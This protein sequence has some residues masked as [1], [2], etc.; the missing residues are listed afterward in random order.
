M[1][2]NEIGSAIG[3]QGWVTPLLTTLAGAFA[4]LI[5][6]A[7]NNWATD[8]R[9]QRQ[10][11]N[12]AAER[13]KER[14]A[15]LRRE[16][17][18]SL[19]GGLSV[20]SKAM[21]SLVSTDFDV[22]ILT[23]SLQTFGAEAA[24]AMM[25]GSD[26]T[27]VIVAWMSNRFNEV[28]S[29]AIR[30]RQPLTALYAQMNTQDE[31]IAEGRGEIARLIKAMKDTSESN[32][33]NAN[34]PNL[35]H[36]LENEMKAQQE[37]Q[38]ERLTLGL[39]FGRLQIAVGTK[40]AKSAAEFAAKHTDLI[41]AMRDDLDLPKMSLNVAKKIEG[42]SETIINNFEKAAAASREDLE[43]IAKTSMVVSA[44]DQPAKEMKG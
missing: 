5:G 7:L 36:A 23:S 26:R 42:N 38:R 14:T 2:L 16:V 6:V 19:V 21:G 4:A 33:P 28:A 41:S 17:Y 25:V 31:F 30:E 18:F 10:L 35:R 1:T 39:D 32:I 34:F 24:K 22:K 9:L 44:S 3:G 20:V 29:E 40:F 11:Q 8:R 12:D 15:S 43:K 37:R 27:V 13:I